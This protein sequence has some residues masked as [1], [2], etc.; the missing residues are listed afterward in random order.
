M[1]SSKK[2]LPKII[3]SIASSLIVLL[4][5]EMGFRFHARYQDQALFQNA[6]NSSSVIEKGATSKLRDI[7]QPSR[8][9]D[10][11]Y[12]LKP[13]LKCRY[14]GGFLSTNRCGFRGKEYPTQKRDGAFRILG[15]GDS[16]MFGQGVADHEIYMAQLEQCFEADF[17]QLG[18]EVINTAVPGYN[19]AM[20]LAT[21]KTK[22]L[23]FEPDLVILHFVANDLKLPNFIQTNRDYWVLKKSFLYDFLSGESLKSLSRD[24]LN[25]SP[26][27]TDGFAGF[28]FDP[29]RTP[30]EYRHM[31]GLPGFTRAL[32]ELQALSDKHRFELLVYAHDKLHD[33]VKKIIENMGIPIL[34]AAP[35]VSRFLEEE[36]CE[37]Y[38]GSRLTL[39]ERDG[40]LSVTGHRLNCMVIYKHLLQHYFKIDYPSYRDQYAKPDSAQL[41]DR[42]DN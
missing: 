16:I 21:I 38:L 6:M 2:L 30:P 10:I 3:L 36:G 15:L 33:S 17:P 37:K 40:H 11:I 19:S 42:R 35:E 27:R 9:T 1:T 8:R 20:Q 32:T 41:E 4:L 26:R 22:G 23:Q 5:L 18:V 39:S 24:P 28:E 12:E 13:N 25:P 31:V 7:I 29:E 14:K 34:E